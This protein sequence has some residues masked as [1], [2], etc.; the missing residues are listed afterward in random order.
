MQNPCH[1]TG[2]QRDSQQQSNGEGKIPVEVIQ[3]SDP[4]SA[5]VRAQFAVS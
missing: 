1:V 2:E 4:L 5:K 3:N